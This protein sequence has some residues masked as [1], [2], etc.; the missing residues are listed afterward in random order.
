MRHVSRHSWQTN[1]ILEE[2]YREEASGSGV[3][4]EG[5]FDAGHEVRELEGFGVTDYAGQGDTSIRDFGSEA[6]VDAWVGENLEEARANYCG[7]GVGAGEAGR[8]CVSRRS[9]FG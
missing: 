7:G 4:A 3:V 9:V 6:G 5:L 8:K 1:R 2:T